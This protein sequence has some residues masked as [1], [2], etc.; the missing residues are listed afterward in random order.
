[1]NREDIAIIG[2]AGVFPGAVDVESFWRNIVNGVGAVEDRPAN[3][4]T[5]EEW[6]GP[7]RSMTRRGGFVPT[8]Y[9]IDPLRFKSIPNVVRHGE[10]EQFLLLDLTADALEDAGVPLD[11]P[12][13]KRTDLIVGFGSYGRKI[14]IELFLRP[15][16]ISHLAR[17]LEG[18]GVEFSRELSALEAALLDIDTDVLATTLPN[19]VASRAANRLDLGGAAYA[20]DGACASSLLA[21]EQGMGRLRDGRADMVLVGGI[22]F[23]HLPGI[24]MFF[25][26]IR[27]LSASG[28][29]RP[30]DRR[31]D[32]IVL[33]EGGGVVVLKRLADARRDGD[34]VYALVKGVGSASD[35]RATGILAPS[36]QG[37]I[38]ALENAYNDAGVD[39]VTVGFVEAHGTGTPAGDSAELETLA[40][41]YGPSDGSF[42]KRSLG[43]VKAMIGHLLPAAGIASLIKA[44]LAL[45]HKVLPPNLSCA[46]PHDALRETDFYLSDEVRPWVHQKG[47]GPRRAGINAFG[48]GGINAHAILEEARPVEEQGVSIA[49][50]PACSHVER[51]S[52]LL[53]FAAAELAALAQR[54]EAVADFVEA[55]QAGLRLVDLAAALA[56]ELDGAAPCRL[57]L[58]QQGLDGLAARLRQLARQVRAGQ[59]AAGEDGLYYEPHARGSSDRLAAVF[60]GMAFPGLIGDLPQHQ[61]QLALHFPEALDVLDTIEARDRHPDDRL[62]MSFL[63][64]PPASLPAEE[65]E[66]LYGRLAPVPTNDIDFLIDLQKDPPRRN[67]AALGMLASSWLSWRILQRLGVAPDML[68][69]ISLGELTAMGAAGM[70]GTL[71]DTLPLIWKLMNPEIEYENQ[72]CLALVGASEEQLAPYLEPFD[73]VFVAL[74]SSPEVTFIGGEQRQIAACC[75]QLQADDYLA[76]PLPFPPVH[77]PEIAFLQKQLAPLTRP[78][79][80]RP[81]KPSAMTVYSAALGA[82]MPNSKRGMRR[83][84]LGNVTKPVRIWQTLRRMH[85][86]GA[87]VFL[88]VGAGTLAAN[89]RTVFTDGEAL[90]LAMDVEGGHPLDQLQRVC[91]QLFVRGVFNNGPELTAGAAYVRVNTAAPRPAPARSATAV[92]LDFNPPLELPSTPPATDSSGTTKTA[93]E[94]A[95]DRESAQSS[96]EPTPQVQIN[97]AMP[98]LGQVV[99]HEPGRRITMRRTLSL[100]R[101]LF[102]G[103]HTLIQQEVLPVE[104]SLPLM[105][106]TMSVEMAAEVASCLVPGQEFVGAENA[107]AAR[108]IDLNDGRERELTISAEYK[109]DEGEGC[110]VRVGIAADNSSL[111]SVDL[112]F[113]TEYSQHFSFKFSPPSG[114]GRYPLTPDQ[115]Y[116]QRFL[117]HGP[118]FQCISRVRA[119]GDRFIQG[120]LMVCDAADLFAGEDPPHLLFDPVVLDGVG[121]LVSLLSID[122]QWSVL[123]TGFKRLGIYRAPPP[124]GTKVPVYVE[125]TKVDEKGLELAANIEVQDGTGHVWFCVEGWADRLFL[126]SDRA[127]AAFRLARQHALALPLEVATMIGQKAVWFSDADIRTL[128]RDWFARIYLHPDEWAEFKKLDNQ[129]ARQR[130]WLM[131]RIAAKDAVR[132][133]LGIAGCHPGEICLGNEAQGRPVV[134]AVPEGASRPQISLAH[135]DGIAVAAVGDG[136][137]GIDIEVRGVAA[138]LELATF[139]TETEQERLGQLAGPD[140]WPTRLWCAK[141][142]AAKALGT[143]L[144]GRPRQFEAV[145]MDADGAVRIALAGGGHTF[146]I[147]TWEQEGTVGALVVGS[148][149]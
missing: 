29:V 82:P 81:L 141:E 110:R 131:G 66:A 60:P 142:A 3:R 9:Y 2:M 38:R 74:C 57:G 104:L 137:Q 116:A 32:G 84:I 24:W 123:P 52:E 77:T 71:E 111:F 78:L 88:Q 14:T 36:S 49:V 20:V 112:L 138:G 89:M 120:E 75:K 1:M 93:P 55:D 106:L 7:L 50:R 46:E 34:R 31:A 114:I 100:E 132:Q 41:V 53:L 98:L 97:P 63:L 13:L 37:Q 136:S 124:A 109:G 105:P 39:P 118:L 107:V 21:L 54:L 12:V 128:R 30:F 40:Q 72:G 94:A 22:N 127:L 42:G 80:R 144:E 76:R 87:K 45:T 119:K 5:G 19:F 146:D 108:W 140:D 92:P 83:A 126:V 23:S 28:V 62:P 27:A 67:L 73:R 59:V 143:G 15:D 90:C 86:D 149:G 48:F 43:A 33:G 64:Q 69:G 4:W 117:F 96:S 103:D 11:A 139:A 44:T 129:A 10:H 95:E 125:F 61:M 101:D 113:G 148:D 91:G 51:P 68:G 6:I 122:Y 121:Q 17:F 85:E 56:D 70:S 130:Q 65:R 102:L 134:K 145:S 18:Q 99:D 147:M 135:C 58:V 35:G 8:P 115:I 25:D 26:R 47:E 133:W 79:D 16:I